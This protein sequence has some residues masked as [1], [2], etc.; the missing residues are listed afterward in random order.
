[1]A[2]S[3]E[4]CDRRSGRFRTWLAAAA[5]ALKV[6]PTGPEHAGIRRAAAGVDA[7]KEAGRLAGTFSAF[8]VAPGLMFRGGDPLLR[9][10]NGEFVVKNLVLITAT[11]VLIAHTADDESGD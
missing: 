1:M 4:T 2:A 11:L 5:A 10:A 9:T 7:S 8:V 3:L 6:S